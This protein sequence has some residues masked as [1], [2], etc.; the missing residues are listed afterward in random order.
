M[1]NILVTPIGEFNAQSYPINPDLCYEITEEELELLG[2]HKLKW[3][4][5]PLRLVTH[6]NREELRLEKLQ[7]LRINRSPLYAAWDTLCANVAF[8]TVSISADKKYELLKWKKQIDDLNEN[9]INNIPEE[10]RYYLKEEK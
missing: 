5:D 9:A 7:E 4:Y 2:E 1:K 10:L 3:E 8:G 6:D